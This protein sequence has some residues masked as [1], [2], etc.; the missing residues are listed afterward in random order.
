MIFSY[1]TIFTN[2][3]FLLLQFY[4]NLETYIRHFSLYF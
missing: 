2:I 3:F 4:L 1:I